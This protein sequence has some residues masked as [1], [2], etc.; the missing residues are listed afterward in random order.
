MFTLS[1]ALTLL[2]LPAA[3]FFIIDSVPIRLASIV[4]AML[5]DVLDG[6]FARKHKT[7]SQLGAILDPIMDKFFVFFSLGILV[8]TRHMPLWGMACIISRDVFLFIFGLYLT[9]TGSWDKFE[10]KSIIWGK[11]TTA[12]QFVVLILV[13]AGVILPWYVYV[14]F[15]PLGIM[16][17]ACLYR[18]FK[19]TKPK[20]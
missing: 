13:V 17:A 3:F 12:A 16:T 1:N 7:V 18:G 10:F 9:L 11:L 8:A 14:L 2:R 15:I 5:S 20:H 4:L 19:K 6:Y